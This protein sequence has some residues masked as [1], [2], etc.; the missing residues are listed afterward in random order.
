MFCVKTMDYSTSMKDT[1][2]EPIVS[3]C[4]LMQ[5]DPLS[6]YLFI[7]C[8]EGLSILIKRAKVRDHDI[9]IWLECFNHISFYICW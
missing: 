9:K 2:V 4:G 3:R 7:L 1:M 6:K 5:D 8:F